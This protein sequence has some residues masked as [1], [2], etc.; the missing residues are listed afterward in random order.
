M[1][2]GWLG[3][4]TRRY[5]IVLKAV[6]VEAASA[7][8]IDATSWETKLQGIS[9]K[10]EPQDVYNVEETGLFVSAFPTNRWPFRERPQDRTYLKAE[11]LCF[12]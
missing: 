12:V 6:S 3:R 9:Q 11:F 2:D 10:F 4:L 1:S 8:G 5:G 7:K